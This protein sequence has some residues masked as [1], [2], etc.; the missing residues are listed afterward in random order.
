MK[1]SHTKAVK[2]D[3]AAT[4]TEMW[5]KAYIEGFDPKVHGPLFEFLWG[6]S[7]DRF[8][9][10]VELSFNH[11]LLKARDFVWTNES[12]EEVESHSEL[13]NKDLIAGK[14]ALD[15]AKASS[16]LEWD[17]PFFWRWQPEVQK[18]M[19]DGTKLFIIKHKLPRF[20]KS[21][22]LPAEKSI[23]NWIVEKIQK[24]R[25]RGYIAAGLALEFIILAELKISLS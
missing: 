18:D 7:V 17:G 2:N 13:D 20:H 5:D 8:V 14:D 15:R 25:L 12:E 21:Q 22:Q 19:R 16:F 10:K 6:I 24:V 9:E 23:F 11:Y 1:D 3:D 4:K